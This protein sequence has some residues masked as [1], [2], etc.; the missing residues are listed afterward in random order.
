MGNPDSSSEVKSFKRPNR[1][2]VT[3][4]A[5]AEIIQHPILLIQ[6]S[7][8]TYSAREQPLSFDAANSNQAIF[9][10]WRALSLIE[11][12]RAGGC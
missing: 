7:D 9:I 3:Q 6:S 12:R 11:I 1:D 4:Q 2:A 10:T 8:C 5:P